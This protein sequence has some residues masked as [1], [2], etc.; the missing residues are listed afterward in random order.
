MA[1]GTSAHDPRSEDFG[2]L[3]V[4]LGFLTSEQREKV[5]QIQADLEQAGSR[6][7]F[8]EVCLDRRLLTQQ[9][10]FLVLNAQGRR[11]LTCPACRKSYSIPESSA[12]EEHRC[13]NCGG[14]L[15]PP[16]APPTPKG[17]G[18][19]L[20][21]QT[22]LR[23]SVRV[24]PLPISPELAALFPGH[25][26]LKQVGQGGM[27]TVFRAR[28]KAGGRL[29]A[30][31]VLAPFLSGNETYVN[32]FLREAKNL[33]K[34]D[35]PNIV[36]FYGTGEAGEY[37]YLLM[38]YVQGVPLS[39]VLQKRG[40]LR[41]AQALKIVR[42]VALGLD[43]AWQH[44]IIHRDVKP[45]NIMMGRDNS[46]KLCDLGLSKELDRDL[47]LSS[48]GSIACSPAYASPEQ[49]QGLKDC[50][51]RTDT[52]SLGVTLYQMATGDLPF[53]GKNAATFLVKHLQVAPPD[54]LSKNPGLSPE[55]GK[56]ILRMLEK[57]RDQRPEPGEVAK[58][59]R[60]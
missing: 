8:G 26:I 17:A 41:E 54:P 21:T 53:K 30:L 9:Q 27:G 56:L 39:T 20:I 40:K 18:S 28:E 2:N 38:E 14:T 13:R 36:G 59:I 25:D 22:D 46:V 45:H 57:N 48:T 47:S 7:R 15:A 33:M 42:D 49:L 23:T 16:D 29:V 11:V 12:R 50:D 37:R 1:S 55:T 34:L 35:H 24:A 6:K 32:R 10:I 44:R 5:F 43:Y 4:A 60:I 58:A 19:P 51:C 3:A 52:Y 31:K